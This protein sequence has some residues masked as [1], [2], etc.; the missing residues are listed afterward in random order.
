VIERDPDEFAPRGR[1]DRYEDPRDDYDDEF[2]KRHTALGRARQKVMVPAIALV[3][4][5][6]FGILGMFV[7]VAAAVVDYLDSPGG[8]ERFYILLMLLIVIAAGFA[9]FGMVIYGG[10]CLLKLRRWGNAATAA[11]VVA[12]LSLAGCYGIL[13]YPFGIWA[14]VV[15]YQHDVREQFR[16]PPD[17]VRDRDD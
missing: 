13:F 5:G 8:D 11:Y 10:V 1:P 9:L 15:L 16:R 3:V 2:G 12:G 6:V 7:A 17:P 4:T 14:L